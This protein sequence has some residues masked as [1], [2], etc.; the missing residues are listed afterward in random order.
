[1]NHRFSVN[2]AAIATLILLGGAI[3]LPEIVQAETTQFYCARNQNAGDTYTTFARTNLGS[4]L[5]R[6]LP[7]LQWN[8]RA[9]PNYPPERRC[10]EVSKRLQNFFNEQNLS[11]IKGGTVNGYPVVC[12]TRSAKDSCD[13]NNVLFTLEYGRDPQTAIAAL[14]KGEVVT[15][16]Q[17]RSTYIDLRQI[18]RRS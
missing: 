8:S 12:A 9:F 1:M 14:R 16:S 3:A 11:I 7:L 6:D 5:K 10:F 15:L 2:C 4:A 17:G 13:S 18:L